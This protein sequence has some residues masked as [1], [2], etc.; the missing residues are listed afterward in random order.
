MH[1]LRV[2]SFILRALIFHADKI[3][4]HALMAEVIRLRRHSN[5][6]KMEGMHSGLGT[7][8]PQDTSKLHKQVSHTLSAVHHYCTGISHS[9]L[10]LDGTEWRGVIYD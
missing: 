7:A 10:N 9:D 6:P 3:P 8:E 1:H 4:H 5:N 2:T